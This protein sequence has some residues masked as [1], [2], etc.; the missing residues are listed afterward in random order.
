MDGVG[1][2]GRSAMRVTVVSPERQVFD[3]E[4]TAVVAPAY[5]GLVGILPRHAPF[6]TLPATA[7]PRPSISRWQVASCRSPATGSVWSL[8]R[9]KPP[10]RSSPNLSLWHW[11]S[12]RHGVS[13]AAFAPRGP[14]RLTGTGPV[15]LGLPG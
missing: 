13:R 8:N 9:S 14:C 10:R 15:L 2:A 4:A 11:L 3:G 5:D 7:A 6:L 1:A 12:G